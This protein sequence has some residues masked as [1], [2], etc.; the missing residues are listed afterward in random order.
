MRD[1]LSESYKG[2]NPSVWEELHT[3]S[4]APASIVDDFKFVRKW[5][6]CSIYKRFLCAYE[7]CIKLLDDDVSYFHGS[8]EEMDLESMSPATD[9]CLVLESYKVQ[10]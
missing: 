2:G 3:L 9:K 1:M 7:E 5:P 8:M 4:P 6:E 10:R